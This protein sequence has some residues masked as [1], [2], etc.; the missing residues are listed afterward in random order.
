MKL[1]RG[2]P[3]NWT[4]RPS[5]RDMARAWVGL[6]V[7]FFALAVVAYLSASTSSFTGLLGPLRRLFF[8]AFGT[9][10]DVILY[11]GVGTALLFFGVL[12]YRRNQ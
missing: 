8:N 7:V 2:Q 10:G 3:D 4:F 9:S 11:A 1:W 5:P 12:K 6:G